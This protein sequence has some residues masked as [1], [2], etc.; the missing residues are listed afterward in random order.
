MLDS[1]AFEVAGYEPVNSPSP[2][3]SGGAGAVSAAA[4]AG[5]IACHQSLGACA[6]HLAEDGAMSPTTALAVCGAMQRMARRALRLRSL[7][8]ATYIAYVWLGAGGRAP[9]REAEA[10]ALAERML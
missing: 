7:S 1:S 8:P 10:E 9:D 3:V 6:F 4:V 2:A 5:C